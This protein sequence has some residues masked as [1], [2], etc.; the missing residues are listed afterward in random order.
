MAQIAASSAAGALPSCQLRDPHTL[1]PIA[2]F[3]ALYWLKDHPLRDID[4]GR[5]VKQ[6]LPAKA[7]A[8]RGR[9]VVSH[10]ENRSGGISS[11]QRVEKNEADGDLNPNFARLRMIKMG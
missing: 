8:T 1:E 5:A 10:E 6:A 9:P 7:Y 3:P 4:A 2:A 11:S